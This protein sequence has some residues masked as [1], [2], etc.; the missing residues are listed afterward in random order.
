MIARFIISGTSVQ[1]VQ[2]RETITKIARNLELKGQVRN[3][4]DGTVEVLFVYRDNGEKIKKCLKKSIEIVEKK[5]LI[6]KKDVK[7]IRINEKTINE[8]EIDDTYEDKNMENKMNDRDFTIIREHELRETV[9]ALHGAGRVFLSASKKV[10][11]L[12]N[13]KRDEVIGRLK[14]VKKE[15]LHIQSDI[16]NV[17]DPVCLK[18]FIADPLIDVSVGEQ[19]ERDLM[20]MLIEFYYNFVQY[21][22]QEKK[23][24]E[25]EEIIIRQID[26]LQKMIDVEIEK[27]K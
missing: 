25:T 24:P 7:E 9:W 15:L 22:K 27:L 20:R 6:D 1:G 16:K 26:T 8:F 19:E 13:Y 17:D 14:S 5:G 18:Q 12:L 23:P 10:E 21:K 4:L 11:D 3:L 2:L